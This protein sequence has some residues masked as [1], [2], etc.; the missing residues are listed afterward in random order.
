MGESHQLQRALAG[1]H[2]AVA[3]DLLTSRLALTDS[4]RREPQFLAWPYGFASDALD[5]IAAATGFIGTVSLRPAGWH[6]EDAP[7]HIG[8]FGITAKT[9][10]DHL[11]RLFLP[12]HGDR[13]IAER[14]Q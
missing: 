2:N 1:P 8:R 3:K 6:E 9:T 12:P 11:A 14:A 7:W 10:P 13:V 5:S 4:V